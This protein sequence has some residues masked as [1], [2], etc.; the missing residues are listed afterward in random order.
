VPGFFDVQDTAGAPV[1]GR[2]IMV[3]LWTRR[4]VLALF[5]V[6]VLLALFDRFG[7]QPSTAVAGGPAAIMRVSAPE[8]VRGGLLYQ[9]RVE[10]RAR[11]TVRYPRLLLDHGWLE[12]MQVNS[13]EPNPASEAS[14]DGR[15][16]LSYDQLNSGDLLVIWMQ[17]QVDPT[18]VGHRPAD[19]ELD[20]ER[21]PVARV[22]RSLTIYP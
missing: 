8:S 5:A 21:T 10:I 13:I 6:F 17:F 2:S 19:V 11:R 14:R 4:V 1:T 18:Y 7:Q 22:E 9:V 20:D 16:V 3:G 12:G 15:L